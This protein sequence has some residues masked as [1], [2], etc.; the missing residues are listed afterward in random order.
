MSSKTM[1]MDNPGDAGIPVTGITQTKATRSHAINLSITGYD[2]AT[3]E[4]RDMRV[5]A[6][7]SLKKMGSSAARLAAIKSADPKTL[8]V[9]W[10]G[11]LPSTTDLEERTKMAG[12]KGCSVNSIDNIKIVDTDPKAMRMV[13]P[14]GRG[15]AVYYALVSQDPNT[16]L[17]TGVMTVL[18]SVFF[19]PEFRDDDASTVQ[20]R[21][22]TWVAKVR[23]ACNR[24]EDVKRGTK[25]TYDE[26]ESVVEPQRSI[27]A[28]K[29]GLM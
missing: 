14:R 2:D 24:S 20:R 23:E 11:M 15:T 8:P 16:K 13:C 10:V 1:D 18:D 28:E 27:R 6:V 21:K 12:A 25:R 19:F 26:I 17:C 7:E 3:G 9:V 4:R 29:S 5:F 22:D